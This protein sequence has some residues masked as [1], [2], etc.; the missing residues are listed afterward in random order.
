M[1]PGKRGINLTPDQFKVVVSL[2]D[3]IGE[4]LG[5]DDAVADDT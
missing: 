1:L 4:L 5:D 3:K 2:K